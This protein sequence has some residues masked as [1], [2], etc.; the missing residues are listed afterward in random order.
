MGDAESE[1]Y[2]G[3]LECLKY[4]HLDST[5]YVLSACFS[6][7]DEDTKDFDKRHLDFI[8]LAAAKGNGLA[9]L[10]LAVWCS[11]GDHGFSA[12]PE[13]ENQYYKLAAD[14]NVFWAQH[15]YGTYL[16]FRGNKQD[17]QREGLEYLTRAAKNGV[18]EAQQ[19]LDQFINSN[20][21]NGQRG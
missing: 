12:S 17:H 15:I 3:H 10:A 18:L 21:H 11:T 4:L 9:Y 13:K 1:W 7:P 5:F 16:Y 19:V 20:E 14:N 8:K 6:M 2:K